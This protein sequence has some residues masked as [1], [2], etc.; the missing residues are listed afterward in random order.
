MF[1][2]QRAI[3]ILVILKPNMIMKAAF[4]WSECCDS[5]THNLYFNEIKK[6]TVVCIILMNINK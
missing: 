3:T 6:Y 5:C 1:W 2:L 4:N